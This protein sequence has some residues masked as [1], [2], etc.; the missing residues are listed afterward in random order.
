[1]SAEV[2]ILDGQL[3]RN[4]CKTRFTNVRSTPPAS[5]KVRDALEAI[6][7]VGDV[8]VSKSTA[9]SAPEWMVTFL[10]NAGN[11]PE[12]AADS[13]AMWGGVVVDVDERRSGT[14]EPVSGS[15]GLSVTGNAGETVTV[16]H[17]A[18]ASEVS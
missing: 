4:C 10:N 1:M 15:F 2:L 14:S 8:S 5:K 13:S 11:L 7:I 12:L 16:S 18:S 3:C 9:S 17:D 6:S